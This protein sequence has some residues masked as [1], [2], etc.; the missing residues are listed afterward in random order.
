MTLYELSKTAAVVLATS[1]NAHHSST[2]WT[3]HKLLDKLYKYLIETV[4]RIAE[5]ARQ[6]GELSQV[7]ADAPEQPAPQDVRAVLH[8]F[9]AALREL[10][11]YDLG[12][13]N[14]VGDIYEKI[15]W[16]ADFALPQIGG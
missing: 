14:M 5:C 3:E 16:Y 2:D 13:D 11:K 12:V 15:S 6:H 8:I 1:W 4:D 9:L 7:G 10:D